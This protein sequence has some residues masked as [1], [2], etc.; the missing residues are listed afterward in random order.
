MVH[1]LHLHHHNKEQQHPS[2]V[3][4]EQ[5]KQEI[6]AQENVNEPVK[7]VQVAAPVPPVAAVEEP[8]P[9][10]L[11]KEKSVEANAEAH[12]KHS[13]HHLH[14]PHPN[15]APAEHFF[16]GVMKHLA[17]EVQTKDEGGAHKTSM[18]NLGRV[19]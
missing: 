5:V 12:P 14:M 19:H 18:A 6:V 10:V 1:M 9:E 4:Q 17:P 15:V 3:V 8:K 11:S 13:H 2:E 16:E 7:E